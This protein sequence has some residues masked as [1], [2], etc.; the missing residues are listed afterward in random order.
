LKL[1]IDT[2]GL[3][4]LPLLLSLAA[5]S[6]AAAAASS[7][8][9]AAAAAAAAAARAVAGVSVSTTMWLLPVW[10]SFSMSYMGV[11]AGNLQVQQQQQHA[12]K[13]V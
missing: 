11:S 12:L 10:K 1:K 7:A 6:A 13:P 8:A 2:N 5:S 4:P 9:R 3:P